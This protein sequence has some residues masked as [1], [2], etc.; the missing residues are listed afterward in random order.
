MVIA[1]ILEPE[2]MDDPAEAIAYDA[3][4][5]SDVNQDFANV[6]VATYPQ[7]TATVLDL[8]TGTARIPIF[9]AEQRPQWQI[10]AADL[11]PS[12]LA[13]GQKNVDAAGFTSQIQLQL[14]DSKDLRFGDRYFDVIMSNSLIHHLPDPLPCFQEMRR[15][16]KPGGAIIL[17]DL[18]RP[19]SVAKI[20]KIIA[21]VDDADF[22]A[23]QLK[24]FR[25]SL[26]AAFTIDEIQAIANQTGLATANVEQ[27]SER[28]WTLIF[29]DEQ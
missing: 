25:D 11:A 8:G 14:A 15:L 12:M 16:L 10:I 22:D 4:D 20:D 13:V 17:R 5:F 7:P 26:F 23:H 27:T 6:V 19:T 9:V 21:G 18:F 28:H 24:L 2:V 29:V 3:M 1:R